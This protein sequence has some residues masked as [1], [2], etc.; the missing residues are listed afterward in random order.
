MNIRKRLSYDTVAAIKQLIIDEK[1]YDEIAGQYGVSVATIER[2]DSGQTY[3]DVKPFTKRNLAR[4]EKIEQQRQRRLEQNQRLQS[5]SA[6]D[7]PHKRIHIYNGYIDFEISDMKELEGLVKVIKDQPEFPNLKLIIVTENKPEA[8]KWLQDFLKEQ[9]DSITGYKR[10]LEVELAKT[11]LMIHAL[12]TDDF[13]DLPPSALAEIEKRRAEWR[14]K[15]PKLLPEN[16]S[17][18]N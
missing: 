6:K 3:T 5:E 13:S 11:Q 2:I 14:E 1:S 7:Q 9:M 10:S 17:E 8:T 18:S 15:N 16:A 12:E 4:I